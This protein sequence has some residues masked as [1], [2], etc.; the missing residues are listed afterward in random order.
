MPASLTLT[1]DD[2]AALDGE[3]G[4]ATRFAMRILVRTAAAM[5]AEVTTNDQVAVRDLPGPGAYEVRLTDAA[6]PHRSVSMPLHVDQSAA[7]DEELLR[8][9]RHNQRRTGW[10][11]WYRA[12]DALAFPSIK[13]GWGLTIVGTDQHDVFVEEMNPAN[14]NEVK[15]N[16]TW[17]PLRVVREDHRPVLR[18]HVGALPVQLR[19][20]MDREEHVEQER[21]YRQ[22]HHGE[23]DQ[24]QQRHTQIPPAEVGYVAA[25]GAE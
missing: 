20:V 11:A 23:H 13:E 25:C 9:S 1:D 15:W 19:G 5:G 12:A 17:E 2:R 21:R 4:D 16:G 8:R 18:A 10:T 3:R 6:A 7:D 24:Q 14:A 22:H